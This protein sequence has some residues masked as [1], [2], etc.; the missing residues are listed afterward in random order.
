MRHYR[1]SF[2]QCACLVR[3][4]ANL[5]RLWEPLLG[6]FFDISETESVESDIAF[7]VQVNPRAL[8]VLWD[9]T[10][11]HEF[12]EVKLHLDLNGRLFRIRGA[13]DRVT[14]VSE[15][16][17]AY[18]IEGLDGKT[19]VEFIC[20]QFSGEIVLDL[21]RLVRGVL[22]ASAM[23]GGFDKLHMSVVASGDNSIAFVGAENAGKTSYMLS[24]L[25][26]IP[27]SSIITNDKT[28][29]PRKIH[30]SPLACFG[31]PYAVSVGSGALACCPEIKTTPTTRMINGEAYFWPAE[32]AGYF[33]RVVK[34][35]GSLT[36]LA[37]VRID[38]KAS[39]IALS[40]INTEAERRCVLL[41]HVLTFSDKSSPYWLLDLLGL[42]PLA[43]GKSFET[44]T[45]IPMYLLQG[46][47]WD[48][49]LR[50]VL[51]RE[52]LC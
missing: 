23:R 32:L 15:F 47:P 24:F 6:P 12:E 3:S 26:Q 16:G 19:Q 18:E 10:T 25:Q 41:T 8:A 4:E 21:L 48:G 37:L 30:K 40:C 5:K 27:G 43:H 1:I 17:V 35:E 38:P 45:K 20:P 44:L 39:G 50:R 46:N 31:L 9:Y 34:T 42:T 52:Y 29:V 49:N 33:G 7:K 36:Q 2:L 11:R 51:N 22:I 14:I 13:N 28:L